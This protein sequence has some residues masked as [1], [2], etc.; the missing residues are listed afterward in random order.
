MSRLSSLAYNISRLTIR[1]PVLIFPLMLDQPG[2]AEALRRIGGPRRLAAALDLSVQAVNQWRRIPPH[3]V[4][5]IE[6]LTGVPRQLLRPDLYPEQ[7]P[8][9]QFEPSTGATG[10]AAGSEALYDPA[11]PGL[12]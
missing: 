7:A 1:N 6:R 9:G 11:A 10:E 12:K 5:E 8:Q 2:L 3:R 4:I